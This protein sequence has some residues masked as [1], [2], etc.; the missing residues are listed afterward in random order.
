MGYERVQGE[1]VGRVSRHNAPRDVGD[2]RAWNV[3]CDEINTMLKRPEFARLG[4]D[5]YGNKLHEPDYGSPQE[6]KCPNCKAPS[7]APC[8]RKEQMILSDVYHELRFWHDER[9]DARDAL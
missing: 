9:I 7:G 3:L 8:V 5:F 4:T 2:I 1:I 6:V